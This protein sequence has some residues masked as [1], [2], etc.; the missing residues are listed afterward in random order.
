MTRSTS[1]RLADCTP[2][3][4]TP[5]ARRAFTPPVANSGTRSKD[6]KECR[7]MQGTVERNEY[8]HAT[9]ACNRCTIDPSKLAIPGYTQVGKTRRVLVTK[10]RDT[11][12][13]RLLTV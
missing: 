1:C 2:G 3:P 9:L 7:D 6:G 11:V 8:S 13:S 12:R 4:F 5:I 10:A